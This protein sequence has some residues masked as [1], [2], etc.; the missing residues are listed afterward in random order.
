[1][2]QWR[3]FKLRIFFFYKI[4]SKIPFC[5]S[6]R[7]P[8]ASLKASSVNKDYFSRHVCLRK[9]KLRTIWIRA[10]NSC[11]FVIS[12]PRKD[13]LH[14]Q[15]SLHNQLVIRLTAMGGLLWRCN[16]DQLQR[17]AS[18]HAGLLEVTAQILIDLAQQT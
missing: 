10:L 16:G 6:G 3:D 11:F 13:L 2:L 5:H 8:Q 15:T 9:K 4:T 7:F 18:T 1:M 14:N 17:R 12:A